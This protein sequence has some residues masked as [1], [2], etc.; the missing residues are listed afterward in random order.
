MSN[1][2]HDKDQVTIR[3]AADCDYRLYMFEDGCFD[4]DHEVR[5]LLMQKVF[6]RQA[7]VISIADLSTLLGAE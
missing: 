2:T 5:N 1:I 4:R 3:L 6:P 7:Y